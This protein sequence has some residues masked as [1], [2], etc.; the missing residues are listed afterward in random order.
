MPMTVSCPNCASQYALP[1]HLLGAQGARVCCPACWHRFALDANGAVVPEDAPRVAV[2]AAVPRGS[3]TIG[4]DRAPMPKAASF[5]RATN[6]ATRHVETAVV[7]PPAVAP[8]APAPAVTTAPS[9]VVANA[10]VAEPTAPEAAPPSIAGPD[11]IHSVVD[12]IPSASAA[13]AEIGVPPA[14]PATPHDQRDHLLA[15][16]ALAA[17]EIVAAEVRD[18]A[19]R[20]RL[21]SEFG[22]RLLEAFDRY[23]IAGGHEADPATFRRAMRERLG[24]EL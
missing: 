15:R 10:P 17:L 22:V 21:F 18:A 5:D 11:L 14:R 9:P 7:A 1:M 19:T 13:A 20:R 8:P 4:A 24:I 16:E 3:H 6:G 23:R 2:P 12:P